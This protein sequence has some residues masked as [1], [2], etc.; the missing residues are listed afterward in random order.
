VVALIALVLY[1]VTSS[2]S[3]SL[4]VDMIS[5]NG[6]PE[7][8]VMQRIFWS[9]TEGATA[10]ALLYAG[11][12]LPNSDGSLKALQSA[13][14]I[15]GL[16]YTFILFWC[17]QSLYLLCKEES[18]ELKVDRKAFGTFI[19]SVRRPLRLL[20]NTLWPGITMGRIVERIGGWP[21]HAASPVMAMRFWAAAFEGM[22]VVAILLLWCGF[23]LYQ[24]CIL[25]LVIYIG[26][27]TFA[28][29]LRTSVRSHCEILHGD[30]LT[31]F[32]CACFAPMFTLTQIEEQLSL[33][34]G[35]L[36]GKSAKA[37]RGNADAPPRTPRE[38]QTP[39][40]LYNI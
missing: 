27:A 8:P 6:H 15:A 18:G 22:Y 36:P 33:L 14:I 12:N 24:W 5:A 10:A 17:S 26:F 37:D 3:G 35:L 29:F 9:F 30:M 4:V 21:L 28:G 40:S 1:F 34:P 19:F 20:Y 16:P 7:P 23:T 38:E 2:D 32:L 39:S 25:A 31:D 13:S 11:K